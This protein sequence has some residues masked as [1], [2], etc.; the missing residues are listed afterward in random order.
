MRVNSNFGP[1]REIVCDN[2]TNFKRADLEIAQFL[3][4]NYGDLERISA[5]KG[6]KFSYGIP[7]NPHRAGLVER[8]VGLFKTAL[9]R[10][11]GTQIVTV[12]D[13][14]HA[15]VTIAGSVNNRPLATIFSDQHSSFALTP[16][17]A[18]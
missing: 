6:I 18:T 13:L 15:C 8:H 10:T 9:F 1:I 11:F 12:S 7:Y 5:T 14:Q 17:D 3:R 4:E 16:R 2:A